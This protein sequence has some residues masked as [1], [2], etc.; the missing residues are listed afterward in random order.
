MGVSLGYYDQRAEVHA[1]YHTDGAFHITMKSKRLP[2]PF[3]EKKPPINQIKTRQH[4]IGNAVF[5]SEEAMEMFLPFKSDSRASVVI[6]M[7]HALWV[8]IRVMA[9]YSTIVHS[10]YEADFI[11]EMYKNYQNEGFD[12]VA[13]N[14]FQ[15]DNFP[16]HKVAVVFYR[17]KGA[18]AK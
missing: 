9:L 5:Y 1:S 17:G 13:V 12:L 8:G 11:A 16:H 6:L 7:S 2:S 10:D 15:L 3:S 14:L 4:L 18:K